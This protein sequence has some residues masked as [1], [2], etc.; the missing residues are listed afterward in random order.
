MLTHCSTDNAKR[1]SQ[2]AS[3]F[4]FSMCIETYCLLSFR[5]CALA[6]RF[7]SCLNRFYIAFKL[8]F[9]QTIVHGLAYSV[10]Y[11]YSSCIE[12]VSALCVF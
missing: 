5:T 9:L 11:Y 4:V 7:S 2:N 12:F 3:L 8:L 1:Q 6:H 10:V